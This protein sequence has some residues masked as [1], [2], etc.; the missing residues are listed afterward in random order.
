MPLAG[1]VVRE[2]KL[3][4]CGERVQEMFPRMQALSQI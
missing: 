3:F 4:Y 1:E 2:G